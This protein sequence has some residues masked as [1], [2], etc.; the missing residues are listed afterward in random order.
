LTVGAVSEVN[1]DT[2]PAGNVIGQSPASGTSVVYGTPVDLLVSLGVQMVT[3]PDVVGLAQATAEADIVAAILTVGNVT[4]AT[5]ATVPVG[6]VISQSPTAGANVVH[7]SAVDIVVSIGEEPVGDV[8][9]PNPDPMTWASVPTAGSGSDQVVDSYGFEVPDYGDSGWA[10]RPTGSVWTFIGG[11]GLSGPNGPWKCNSTSPDQAGDQFA[12]LQGVATISKDLTGLTI[13]ATYELSFF[14]STRTSYGSSNDLS[15]ILDEG[16]ATEVVIYNSPNVT[17][18]TWE[19]RTTSQFVA[20]KTSYTLTLGTTNP[21]GGD[22]S[23]IVDGLEV[24]V[25]GDSETEI[26]MTATTATDASDVEYYFA[27]IEDAAQDSGWQD[28]AAYTAADLAGSTEYTFTV[29]ARD[30]SVNQN[31]TALSVAESATTGAV[32]VTVPNVVGMAQAAAEA[33]ITAASLTVGNVTTA[34][35]AIVAVGNVISQNPADGASAS[36][37]S[38]VDIVVSLGPDTS[39]DTVTIAK[40]EFKS[41]KSE[42]KVEANSSDGGNVTLTVVGYGQMTY[43]SDKNKYEYKATVGSAPSTVTVT[44]SGGGSATKTVTQK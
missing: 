5:S 18:T 13:G 1:S 37:G 28:S 31:A 16:L 32:N 20:A 15:V 17:N 11:S 9:A 29:Q 39:S 6:D 21:L 35:S 41:D 43:K 4:T 38:S 8:T 34:Y 3:V 42:L 10:Y 23:T 24:K 33:A 2:V 22:R 7:H 19:A 27:C 40:A 44:S 36:S 30:K 26:T 12:F 14:E 25:L